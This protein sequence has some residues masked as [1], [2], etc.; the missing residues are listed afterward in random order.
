MSMFDV[1]CEHVA[2]LR[3]GTTLNGFNK[4]R[5]RPQ[6]NKKRSACREQDILAFVSLDNITQNSFEF[7]TNKGSPMAQDSFNIG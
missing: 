4:T 6:Q 5:E 1:C 7:E 2:L 3:N